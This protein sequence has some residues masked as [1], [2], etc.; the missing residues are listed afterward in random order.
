MQ[1]SPTEVTFA[2]VQERIASRSLQMGQHPFLRRLEDEKNAVHVRSIAEGI[3]FFVLGFQDIIR[4]VALS[5]RAPE[6]A[7]FARQN[8]ADDRGHDQWFLQDMKQLGARCDVNWLFSKEHQVTRDV[9]YRRIADAIGAAH[10]ASR[11]ALALALEAA[12]AEFFGRMVHLLEPS[13][14]A[15]SLKYFGRHHQMV[16]QSHDMFEHD[17]QARLNRVVV[18]EGAVSE[19]WAMIERTFAEV[20]AMASDINAALDR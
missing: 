3:S 8:E 18:P 19:V 4:Y 10:D 20:E 6:L 12:A 5:I 2:H 17:A 14:H 1:R 15:D 9:T 11:F 13:G 7:E 16:E